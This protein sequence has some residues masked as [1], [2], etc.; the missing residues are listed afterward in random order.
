MDMDNEQFW[1]R[2]LKLRKLLCSQLR[3]QEQALNTPKTRFHRLINYIEENLDQPLNIDMLCNYAHLSKYHFHRQCSAFFGMPV[4]TLIK[5]LKLKRAA[6]QLAYRKELKVIDIAFDNGYD[7]HEAFTRAFKKA[8]KA[9]PSVFRQSPDWLPW[10]QEY[11]NVITLRKKL[12]SEQDTFTVELVTFEQVPVGVFQH[13]G[14]PAKLSQSIGQFI[15]WRKAN[16]LSPNTSRTFNLLYDDPNQVPA[17]Q[18]RLDLACELTHNVDHN[19]DN[20][21]IQVI[22]AGLCAKVRHIGSDDTIGNTINYLYQHW[23]EGTD[24]QIRDF[25]LFLERVSF[26]PEVPEHKMVTDVFLPLR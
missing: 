23:L 13:R 17:D 20:I 14:S 22:P 8:F 25:P 9:T 2:E 12:M 5:L 4:M 1:S 19:K 3:K 16:K 24:Y 6:F 15:E 26:F 10:Q 7:S 21:S 18:F 11:N